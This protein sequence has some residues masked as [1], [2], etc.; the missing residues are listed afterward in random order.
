MVP[1]RYERPK[2]RARRGRTGAHFDD[3]TL[4]ERRPE[5]LRRGRL[6]ARRH[7]VGS[8]TVLEP[9]TPVSRPLAGCPSRRRRAW[10]HGR[11]TRDAEGDW[12]SPLN[13]EHATGVVQRAYYDVWED[14]SSVSD[15]LFDDARWQLDE[16]T[17]DGPRAL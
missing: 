11:L 6:A 4:Q 7:G 2:R 12:L 13:F 8:L 14:D 16:N 3:D 5:R 1:Q 15:L 9:C 17:S 10:F